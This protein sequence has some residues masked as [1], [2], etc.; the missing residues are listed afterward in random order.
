MKYALAHYTNRFFIIKSYYYQF[1]VL[2]LNKL[3]FRYGKSIFIYFC[4]L[5]MNHFC[6]N[7]SFILFAYKNF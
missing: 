6:G 2:K 3:I 5:K 4:I 1:K 7:I